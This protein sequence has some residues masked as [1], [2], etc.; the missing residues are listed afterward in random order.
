MSTIKRAII[1]LLAVTIIFGLI[2]CNDKKKIPEIESDIKAPVLGVRL[3]ITIDHDLDKENEDIE[4]VRSFVSRILNESGFE[5]IDPEN[6]NYNLTLQIKIHGSA[7]SK[8]YSTDLLSSDHANS[9][10]S[11]SGAEIQGTFYFLDS[12]GLESGKSSFA[13]LIE[14]PYKI[15]S[16]IT[17]S[18]NAPLLKAFYS[19]NFFEELAKAIAAGYGKDAAFF[20]WCSIFQ[21]YAIQDQQ[22]SDRYFSEQKENAIKAIEKSRDVR[23]VKLLLNSN[24]YNSYGIMRITDII[25]E[26]GYPA[27]D[28]LINVLLSNFEKEYKKDNQEENEKEFK[29]ALAACALGKIGDK[30]AIDALT[31]ANKSKSN[32]VKLWSA[33]ALFKLGDLQKI[34]WIISASGD[35][36]LDVS[37]VIA[38]LG[39]TRVK[40][41]IEPLLSIWKKDKELSGRS[42]NIK[43]YEAL[44]KIVD[45]DL[46]NNY[47][48]WNEW[49]KENKKNY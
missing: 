9:V 49:W 45:K 15:E 5:I 36:S 42:D 13:A 48:K 31:E 14:P 39:E 38:A 1:T 33:F 20:Y 11:Y 16:V 12:A 34:D 3:K 44:K 41:A 8:K 22:I 2:N 32:L 27:V 46:E 21:Y 40:K 4:R 18:L 17:S 37:N 7:K 19:S 43:I 30:R 29:A 23:T 35:N 28:P 47:E 6:G 10:I 24:S 26:I 25:A